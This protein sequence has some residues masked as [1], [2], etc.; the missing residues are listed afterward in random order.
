MKLLST[1]LG[2]VANDVFE[3]MANAEETCIYCVAEDHAAVV[4][5][6][7]GADLDAIAREQIRLIQIKHEGGTIVLSPGDVDI[8]IFTEDFSGHVYRD[9]IVERIIALLDIE[10]DRIT[11]VKN[12]ILVDGKK[13]IGYGSRRYGDILYTAIHVSIN[14]DL[15]LIQKICTKPMQKIPGSLIE[16]GVCSNDIVNILRDIFE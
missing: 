16:Y 9:L 13:V 10:P 6:R 4:G 12:D 2:S 11:R 14:A 1:T 7:L 3:A 5:T 15:V 8:G